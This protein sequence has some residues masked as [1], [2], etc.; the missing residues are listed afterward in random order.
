MNDYDPFGWLFTS[1]SPKE[2]VEIFDK[3]APQTKTFLLSFAL[4]SEYVK[5][6]LEYT[7]NQKFTNLVTNYLRNVED[8]RV[9]IKF[10]ENMEN[11]IK[12]IFGSLISEKF[13]RKSII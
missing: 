8:E 1:F 11:H 6:V 12:D 5:L 3:E 4:N 9:D 7:N 13:I 10:I 2:F